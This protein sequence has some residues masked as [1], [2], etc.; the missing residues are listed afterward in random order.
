LRESDWLATTIDATIALQER[1]K[2]ADPQP[3]GDR[4][5]SR[6]RARSVRAEK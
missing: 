1:V 4:L 5:G 6:L 3:V 2:R